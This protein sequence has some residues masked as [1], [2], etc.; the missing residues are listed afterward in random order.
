MPRNF[1]RT[2]LSL[3]IILYSSSGRREARISDLS[4]GGCFID[5]IITPEEGETVNFDVRMP[6]GE[7]L[8]LAGEVVYFMPRIGFGIN[9]TDLDDEKKTRLEQLILAN[10][11]RPDPKPE[12]AD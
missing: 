9:F 3:E 11:G 4:M 5:T 10:G 1:E 2:S 7:W 6:G 8:K 12:Y